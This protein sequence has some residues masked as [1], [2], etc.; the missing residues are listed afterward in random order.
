M[1]E[2]IYRKYRP[3]NFGD[4]LGQ[5]HIVSLLKAAVGDSK[6]SHAYLFSGPRGTGKTSVARILSNEIGCHEYDRLEM[7]AASSRG[8]D[9]IRSLREGVHTSPM[10]GDFKVYIIDEVHML[11]KEAFNALLKTL[12]EP[13]AH[14]VFVLATTEPEKLP[15]TVVSR[16][17]HFAFKKIPEDI[18][19]SSILKTAKKEGVEIDM[20]T[21]GLIALFADGSFRDAQTMLDQL[22]GSRLK[23]IEGEKARE[24]LAAPS[25]EL[26]QG[27]VAA[28]VEKNSEKG[29]GITEKVVEKGISIQL[30]LKFILR[31]IRALLMMK[32]SSKAEIQLEKVLGKDEVEFLKTKKEST[33]VK[34]LGYTLILLLEAY[35]KVN[36][37]Y[38]PQLPLELVLAKIHLRSQNS[39]K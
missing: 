32:L 29:L 8:I 10:R 27:F 31:N 3:K 28:L 23:K 33:T 25:K 17:Q 12:E 9:E 4:V 24:L 15:D 21:A 18:L 20:E 36:R 37:S 7:D 6:F 19:R 35:D 38:L 26:I 34:E 2:V 30:F 22:I 1:R 11:T 39:E 5:D 13:P 16:C 14:A